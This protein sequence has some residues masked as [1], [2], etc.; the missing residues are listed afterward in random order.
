VAGK[1]LRLPSRRPI[2]VRAPPTI[3]DVM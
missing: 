1:L 3:T 2:G